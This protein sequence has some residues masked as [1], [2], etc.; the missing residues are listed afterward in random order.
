MSIKD[1]KLPKTK[2]DVYHF[3]AMWNIKRGKVVPN[4]VYIQALKDGID[5]DNKLFL[6]WKI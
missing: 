1:M 4:W 3:I 2:E 5:F 6:S